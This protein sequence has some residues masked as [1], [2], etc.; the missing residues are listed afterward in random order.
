MKSGAAAA[1]AQRRRCAGAPSNGMTLRPSARPPRSK[2]ASP[3]T[4][5]SIAST[6]G[7]HLAA[8]WR[9]CGPEAGFGRPNGNLSES[10]RAL[11]TTRRLE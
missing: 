6:K 7:S 1:Q 11:A 3:K 4:P 5:A 2:S 10:T 9:H 8:S